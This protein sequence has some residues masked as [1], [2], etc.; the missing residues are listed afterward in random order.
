MLVIRAVPGVI[1]THTQTHTHLAVIK[2]AHLAAVVKSMGLDVSLLGWRRVGGRGGRKTI[3]TPCSCKPEEHCC[4]IYPFIQFWWCRYEVRH[5]FQNKHEVGTVGGINIFECKRTA[6]MS[7]WFND[8]S[9][10]CRGYVILGFGPGPDSAVAVVLSVH[11]L[12]LR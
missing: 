9:S 7:R 4:H 3:Y 12:T 11:E 8:C 2:R 6:F 1:R 10:T 5:E